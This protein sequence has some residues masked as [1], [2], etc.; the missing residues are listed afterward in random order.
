M[1]ETKSPDYLGLVSGR[2]IRL[3]HTVETIIFDCSWENQVNLGLKNNL[4]LCQA[5]WVK[6]SKRDERFEAFRTLKYHS[7]DGCMHSIHVKVLWDD[8]LLNT[9]TVSCGWG[10]KRDHFK[11]IPVGNRSLKIKERLKAYTKVEPTTLVEAIR[12]PVIFEQWAIMETP[13]HY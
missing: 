11:G 12:G 4:P 3:A 9:G 6:L 10:G 5:L 8:T 13:E 2:S 1:A 7:L